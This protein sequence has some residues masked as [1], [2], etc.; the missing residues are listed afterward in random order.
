MTTF[1]HLKSL[2]PTGRTA[3]HTL[4]FGGTRPDGTPLPAS[5]Q[6][7]H[8]GEGNKEWTNAVAKHNTSNPV[9]ARG[10]AKLSNEDVAAALLE[11]DR[12]LFPRHVV[13]GWE[14]V[15]D[16]AGAPVSFTVE[17]CLDLFA[18]LPQWILDEVRLFAF[19]ASNFVSADSPTVAGAN[20]LAGN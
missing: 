4:P 17:A 19:T 6:L 16:A 11:R 3:W 10:F 15:F 1:D 13:V 20:E 5:F 12:A 9:R 8:A 14:N 7:R 18:V 2:N